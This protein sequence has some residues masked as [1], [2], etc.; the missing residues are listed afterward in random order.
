MRYGYVGLGNLGGHLAAGLLKAG[1]PVTVHDRD[2]AL[3]DRHL[4]LGATWAGSAGDLAAG[5]DHVI[6]CL[7]SP[8]VSE[9]VL[10]EMLPRMRPGAT[11]VENSTLGRDDILRLGALAAE[12]GVQLMEAPVTG[13]VHLA[14]RGEITVLAGGDRAL[15]DLHLPALQAI[16]NRIFHMGPLGSAAVIKVITNMLA[17]IHLVADG[18]ALMLAKRGGLDLKTAWEAITASSGTSFVHETEG[19][20]ILNGSYDIAFTNDLALKDLGF[21]LGFG[22]EFGVPLELAGLTEQTFVK[23]KAAYGGSAQSTQVVKL[24]EDVLGVDLRAEGFPA[25]LE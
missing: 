17:F 22:R 3:A 2:R 20:L 5:V 13:G 6:T 11:W 18:E 24:L 7:P 8:A 16:G 15:F 10:R 25:R 1:F 21:A 9:T 12:H 14:A 19:Q 23:A 4:A